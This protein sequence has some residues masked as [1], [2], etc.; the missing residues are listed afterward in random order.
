M[1]GTAW[2]TCRGASITRLVGA[3]LR[4]RND[5]SLL[6]QRYMQI[7]GMAER[8]PHARR[9]SKPSVKRPRLESLLTPEHSRLR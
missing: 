7:E 3:V 4:E 2:R 6:Q 9:L 1:R 8:T 5:K